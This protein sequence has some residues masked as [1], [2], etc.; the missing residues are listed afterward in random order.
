MRGWR[1]SGFRYR[2]A[3][4]SPS[5]AWRRSR[6]AGRC[7]SCRP[8]LCGDGLLALRP[9]PEERAW[10]GP[11][12]M[13]NLGACARTLALLTERVGVVAAL[14]FHPWH[15]ALCAD[16][17]WRRAGGSGGADPEHLRAG[18]EPDEAALRALL[19]DVEALYDDAVGEPWPEDPGEQLEAAARAM[20]L[21]W[22]APT[23]RILRQAKGAP[24][25][26]GLGF[27]VQRL[28]LS[29]RTGGEWMRFA[30]ACLRTER[31]AGD[32]RR[33]HPAVAGQGRRAP[34]RIR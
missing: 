10:G 31:R 13:L 26:A 18:T 4:R 5:S 24:G 6:P 8:D 23:A 28:A 2:R 25:N 34:A 20:A 30:A 16:G 12:A 32:R 14:R 29:L 27:V 21:A 33:V 7:R 11:S 15:P 19:A 22:R 9:S 1:P 17:A 3:W